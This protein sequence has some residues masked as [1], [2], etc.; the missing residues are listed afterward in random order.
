MLLARSSSYARRRRLVQFADPARIERPSARVLAIP[1][2]GG[3]D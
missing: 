2:R 3:V 1:P